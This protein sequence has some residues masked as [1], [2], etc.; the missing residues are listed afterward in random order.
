MTARIEPTWRSALMLVAVAV[1]VTVAADRGISGAS[2]R[3]N[4]ASDE[5]LARL[6]TGR[7]EAEIV[8]LG[9]SRALRLFDDRALAEA[10]GMTV[11]NLA[12]QSAST[13]LSAAVLA[14]HLER[15]GP[16]RIVIHEL[17]DLIRGDDAV[18]QV[19]MYTTASARLGDLHRALNAPRALAGRALHAVTF[20]NQAFREQA[21]QTL[22]GMPK[23]VFEGRIPE[24]DLAALAADPPDI[25]YRSLAPNRAALAK[26]AAAARQAG[27]VYVPIIAPILP[28]YRAQIGALD[29]WRASVAADLGPGVEILDFATLFADAGRF[30][31]QVHL[32]REGVDAFLPAFLCRAELPG[33]ARPDCASGAA[34]P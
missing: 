15:Y 11:A 33:E 32:N 27:G 31:D 28:V 34:R 14:D 10:T 25:R 18:T 8:I 30:K 19:E 22:T 5:P 2:W 24:T 23:R 6:Y 12:V 26:I 4:A 1:A 16:A 13:R 9:N 7:G 21:L 20:N 29:D 3:I 17:T